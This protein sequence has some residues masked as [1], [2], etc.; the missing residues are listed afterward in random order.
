MKEAAPR[1]EPGERDQ[2]IDELRL[3]RSFSISIAARLLADPARFHL[4]PERISTINFNVREM[5]YGLQK[6]QVERA[7]HERMEKG[8]KAKGETRNGGSQEELRSSH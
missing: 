5:T 7:L 1:F 6:E 4:S 8:T 3:H 2:R